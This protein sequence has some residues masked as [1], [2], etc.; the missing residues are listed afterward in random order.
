MFIL[1]NVRCVSTYFSQP[2]NYKT[3]KNNNYTKKNIITKLT[4]CSVAGLIALTT[5]G[6]TASAE[7]TAP[8]GYVKLTFKAQSDTA[9]SLPMDRPRVFSGA[10]ASVSGN[11]VNISSADLT[12][13]ALQYAD[14]SQQEK[15]YLLFTTGVLEGRSFDV[16]SNGTTSITLAQDGNQ[17]VQALLGSSSNDSFVIRPH[18]TLDTLFPNGDG[19]PQI[20][21][22]LQ[23][24]SSIQTK[25][26]NVDGVNIAS[27][28]TYQFI[29]GTGWVD[30]SN[31]LAGQVKDVVLPRN[32]FYMMRNLTNADVSKN[33]V[34]DVPLT[35][36]K[37]LL[38]S[39]VIEQDSHVAF[40]FP[41]DV[42]LSETGLDSSAAFKS[43]SNVLTVDGD[44]LLVFDNDEQG[45]NKAPKNSYVFITGS[46]WVDTS[47]PLGGLV[48]PAQINLAA[49]SAFIV[50]KSS[51]TANDKKQHQTTLPYNPFAE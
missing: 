7:V 8:V 3:M 11:V 22:V 40:G 9:F 31:L 13:N 35:D 47:N 20:T 44:R 50:R 32:S 16:V 4:A 19:F 48:N 29:T 49:G 18:W 15:Y 34:G 2:L 14:G 46:G 30:K 24:G 36:S 25:P 43:T 38:T 17:S 51:E 37:L 21:S 45:F 39:N 42:K 23:S 33:L 41:V 27:D 10:V 6:Q 12:A 1:Q 28:H 26:N 5:V